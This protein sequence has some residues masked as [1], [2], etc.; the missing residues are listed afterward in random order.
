[1]PAKSQRSQAPVPQVTCAHCASAMR[2][3]PPSPCAFWHTSPPNTLQHLHSTSSGSQGR[4]Q[5]H[6]QG[7][8]MRA[9]E[10]A[11]I[12]V[13]GPLHH[14]MATL[15]H[16]VTAAARMRKPTP[17]LTQLT[18]MSKLLQY[19]PRPAARV[20]CVATHRQRAPGR[21]KSCTQS[22]LYSTCRTRTRTQARAFLPAWCRQT[23]RQYSTR[24]FHKH[25]QSTR[26]E[27][28]QAL[29]TREA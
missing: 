29:R 11:C 26:A 17:Q 22:R 14:R 5:R 3:D 25:Q 9:H 27:D 16:H 7:E 1:M 12:T 24:A 13:C 10:Q 8:R 20:A 21:T 15:E 18:L 6:Q 2:L 23:S 28:T 19:H 4:Q